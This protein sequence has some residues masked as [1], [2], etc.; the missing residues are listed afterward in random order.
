MKAAILIL[1]LALTLPLQGCVLLIEVPAE[2]VK[3]VYKDL[4]AGPGHKGE[5]RKTQPVCE[6]TDPGDVTECMARTEWE[7]IPEKKDTWTPEER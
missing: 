2:M 7:L 3:A 6:L 4:S 1:A 5:R